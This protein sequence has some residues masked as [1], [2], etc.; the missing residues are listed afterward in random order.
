M[1]EVEQSETV[2][3]SSILHSA[4]RDVSWLITNGQ[5]YRISFPRCV[6]FL[7]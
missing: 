7:S 1:I 3:E 6:C 4:T 5:F 2:L